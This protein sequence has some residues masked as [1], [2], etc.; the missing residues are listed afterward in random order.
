MHSVESAAFLDTNV[1]LRYILNDDPTQ[2]PAATRLFQGI[3]AGSTTVQLSDTIIFETAY[4]LE[5][6]YRVPRIEIADSLLAFLELPGV[7]LSGKTHYGEV[8][9]LWI[10][11][12]GLSFADCFH[13]VCA[14]R[15][16]N[17][18]IFS[19]DKGFDRIPG[20]E[21]REPRVDQS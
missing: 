16:T 20:I 8:C 14:K 21:R 11:N 4:T 3:E 13:A 5:S 10:A 7:L 18:V 9:S 1:L 2:S 17:G 6:F 12:R 19:F 15:F